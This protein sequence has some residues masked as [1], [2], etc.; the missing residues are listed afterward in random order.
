MKR[1]LVPWMMTCMLLATVLGV[2]A[3]V[4]AASAVVWCEA[5]NRHATTSPSHG[6]HGVMVQATSIY[7]SRCCSDIYNT[8]HAIGLAI[9][10]DRPDAAV[11]AAHFHLDPQRNEI[12]GYEWP[13]HAE[14]TITIGDHQSPD[15]DATV[16]TSVWGDFGTGTGE[17]DIQAGHLVTVTDGVSPRTHT[18]TSLTITE[19]DQGTNT[20]SG[21]AEAGSDVCV[22]IQDHEH[23]ERMVTADAEGNW[24]ADFSEA[25][26]DDHWQCPLKSA[27]GYGLRFLGDQSITTFWGRRG[28]F[29]S[30]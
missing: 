19:V 25:V 5:D 1:R 21:T 22:H 7:G 15:F 17:F 6:E 13:L 11:S 27:K 8:H 16:T 4:P 24:T 2:A 29:K 9:P 18:V 26:G 28:E 14:V 20:I 30:P 3:S 12:W 10:G 23:V